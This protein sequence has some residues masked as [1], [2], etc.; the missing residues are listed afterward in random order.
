MSGREIDCSSWLVLELDR[1]GEVKWSVLAIIARE[2]LPILRASRAR[3]GEYLR[4]S[5]TRGVS[6]WGRQNSIKFSGT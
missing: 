5:G 6:T 2:A 3:V 4:R 1:A